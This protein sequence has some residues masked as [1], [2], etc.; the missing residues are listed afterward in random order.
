MSWAVEYQTGDAW[1]VTFSDKKI[2]LKIINE[3]QVICKGMPYI[4]LVN[5]DEHLRHNENVT[6]DGMIMI[7]TVC[8]NYKGFTRE[9][10]MRA[11]EAWDAMAMMAHLSEERFKKHVVSSGHVVKN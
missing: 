10:V 11:T 9:Q 4:D 2:T 1:E 7:E 8:S 3:K 6:S 5:P